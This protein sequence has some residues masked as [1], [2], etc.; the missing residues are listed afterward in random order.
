ML[1]SPGEQ[2]LAGQSLPAFWA[3][4]ALQLA[5]LEALAGQ[6]Q[7]QKLTLASSAALGWQ[8]GQQM[9]VSQAHG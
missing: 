9:P 3:L 7:L 1:G 8:P 6:H 2:Q 4:F 5:L